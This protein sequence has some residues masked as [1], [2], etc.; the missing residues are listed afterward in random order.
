M[1]MRL[2]E[3]LHQKQLGF[4]LTWCIRPA[5]HL[6][7]LIKSNWKRQCMNKKDMNPQSLWKRRQQQRGHVNKMWSGAG[8]T[9]C[10]WRPLPKTHPPVPSRWQDIPGE[11]ELEEGH[12]RD[13]SNSQRWSEVHSESRGVGGEILHWRVRSSGPLPWLG[14]GN[15]S[16]Q[17]YTHFLRQKS[18]E[19]AS[20]ETSSSR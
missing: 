7:P 3:S 14:S 9:R 6:Y 8:S 1:N 4:W 13:S 20:W 12:M 10:L 17:A 15:A 18:R 11:T 16:S 2:I 19:F 5:F